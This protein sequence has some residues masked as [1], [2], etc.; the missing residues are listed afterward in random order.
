MTTTLHLTCPTCA[1]EDV[2]N[3]PITCRIGRT[4]HGALRRARHDVCAVGG[5]TEANHDAYRRAI[6]AWSQHIGLMDYGARQAE[7]ATERAGEQG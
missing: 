1:V 4:L 5:A 6:T 7:L 2:M 3:R